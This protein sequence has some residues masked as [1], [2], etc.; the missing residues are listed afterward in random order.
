MTVMWFRL[1]GFYE[2]AG[3]LCVFY[4]PLYSRGYQFSAE[5]RTAMDGMLGPFLRGRLK[6]ELAIIVGFV[7]FLL[8]VAA[9]VFLA[10]ASNEQLDAFLA[11]PPWVWL[12]G[13]VAFAGAILAPILLRLRSK[14]RSQLENMGVEASEP[15]RP[16]FF[17]VDGTFSARRLS[18]A[19]IGL[20]V[21][22]VLVGSVGSSGASPVGN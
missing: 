15:R 5:Q 20:C 9:T 19:I 14:I 3:D 7:T 4:P 1:D 6:L 18:F 22:L 12:V 16:D 8:M 10:T 21:I 2:N 11:I 13:A 17:V